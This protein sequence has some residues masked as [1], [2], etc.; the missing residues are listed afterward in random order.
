MS[1]GN[2]FE[3]V[4]SL[5]DKLVFRDITRNDMVLSAESGDLSKVFTVS[6]AF[7]KDTPEIKQKVSCPAEDAI[8][9]Q[10]TE[11]NNNVHPSDGLVDC[12]SEE[13]NVII[14]KENV[15]AE[16][17]DEVYDMSLVVVPTP[18]FFLLGVKQDAEENKGC[19]PSIMLNS[20]S[21]QKHMVAVVTAD[22]A[23]LP[24]QAMGT[25]FL[26]DIIEAE[27][28][29]E[30]IEDSLFDVF[31][32]SCVHYAGSIWRSIGLNEDGLSNF[33]IEHIVNDSNIAQHAKNRG[34]AQALAA[35]E[36][37]GHR[38]LKKYV[39]EVVHAEL[40]LYGLL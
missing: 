40:A 8:T 6:G 7:V 36:I 19:P 30:A 29:A 26:D 22:M 1:G 28:N 5:G 3:V 17:M 16:C 12:F 15:P 32:N 13:S 9:C 23:H 31:T 24:M 25:A 14:L 34:G 38:A 33:I 20:I 2:V 18:H 21:G 39:A 4:S 27:A 37:G 10:V 11:L 35:V